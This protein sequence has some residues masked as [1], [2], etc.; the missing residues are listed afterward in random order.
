MTKLITRWEC[1]VCGETGDT[2]KGAEAH[3]RKNKTHSTITR[4][5]PTRK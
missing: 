2:D 4:N 3:M 1:Y 5:T